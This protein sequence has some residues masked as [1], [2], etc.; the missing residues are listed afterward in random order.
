MQMYFILASKPQSGENR[1]P[2]I[3]LFSY[4][5]YILLKDIGTTDRK[6]Y[7]KYDGKPKLKKKESARTN[8]R[9]IKH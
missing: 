6:I 8:Q 2:I 4:Q 5:R 1:N 9:K 3:E 7:K